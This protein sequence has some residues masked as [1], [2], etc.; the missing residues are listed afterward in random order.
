[1]GELP[2]ALNALEEGGPAPGPVSPF[3]QAAQAFRSASQRVSIVM[4]FDFRFAT[5][6]RR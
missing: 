2:E 6:N 1:M 5:S 4:G 3:D